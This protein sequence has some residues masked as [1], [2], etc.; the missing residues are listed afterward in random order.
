MGQGEGGQ[1]LYVVP[2]LKFVVAV[3]AGND[4]V[5]SQWMPPTRAMRKI[6]LGSI[7]EQPKNSEQRI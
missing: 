6:V 5:E 3:T 4:L 7:Q 2:A 1:R